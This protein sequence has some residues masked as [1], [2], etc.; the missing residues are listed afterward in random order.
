M[1]LEE[2]KKITAL[3]QDFTE[4]NLAAQPSDQIPEEDFDIFRERAAE[5]EGLHVT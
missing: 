5:L 3:A 1:T 2:T 4:A